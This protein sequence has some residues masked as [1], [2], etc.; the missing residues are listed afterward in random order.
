[1]PGLAVGELVRAV[2]PVLD[3]AEALLVALGQAGQR[4]VR[5]G[6]VGGTAVGQG[7]V[8]AGQ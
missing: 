4:G 7:Q 2:V 6:E 3:D 5:P 8:H 1:V